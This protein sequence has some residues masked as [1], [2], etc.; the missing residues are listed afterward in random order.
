MNVQPLMKMA[1]LDANVLYA[2]PIRD[3]LLHLAERN[4]YTP[5]WTDEIHDE[6]IRSLCLHRKDIPI[7]SL[8]SAKNA[9]NIA[10]PDANITNYKHK[11]SERYLPDKKDRHVL[12]AAI[13][14]RSR[15][16]VTF[17][18]RDF[19]AYVLE[20]FGIRSIHPDLFISELIDQHRQL[21]LDALKTQS[22]RLKHPP[23]SANEVMIILK[24][25]G[26]AKSM[27]QL[28]LIKQTKI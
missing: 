20:I 10:F 24:K 8:L 1:I 13:I 11:I 28:A 2:A 15:T 26:L 14:S 27:E 12:A 7:Q 18:V 16:I 21:C 5:R 4:L 9:M 19:P 17:N 25:C 22:N 3:Y 6:W 23:M